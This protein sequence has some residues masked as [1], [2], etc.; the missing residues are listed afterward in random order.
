M[1]IKWKVSEKSTGRYRSFIPRRWPIAYYADGSICAA[2]YCDDEYTLNRA[3]EGKHRLLT[4][5]IADY[6]QEKWAWLQMKYK[7]V[8]L[9][10]A[11]RFVEI[12]LQKHP[13]YMPE[14]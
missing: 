14:N 13:E 11:K 1:R 2:I 4:V 10:E 3:K 5:R 8:T 6:S 7:P 9:G 12:V